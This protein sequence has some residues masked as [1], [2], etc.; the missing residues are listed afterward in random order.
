MIILGRLAGFWIAALGPMALAF[1]LA[2]CV[3]HPADEPT[4]APRRHEVEIRGFQ[5]QP[6]NLEVAVG[7]TVVW[8]NRDAV[9]HT[10]TA[11]DGSWDSG[12][13]GRGESWTWVPAEPGTWDY[14]CDFHPTM[15]ASLRVKAPSD[16]TRG[17]RGD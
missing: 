9:P 7:D 15:K 2:P 4:E 17:E 10:A 5:F 3:R 13:L 11:V 6:R 8:I 14:L 16:E 12:E 1:P